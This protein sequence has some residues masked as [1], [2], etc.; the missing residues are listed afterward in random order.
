MNYFFPISVLYNMLKD[1]GNE[2]LYIKTY[3]D[4]VSKLFPFSLYSW[5][6]TTIYIRSYLIKI[7]LAIQ[8]QYCILYSLD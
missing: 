5:F 2:Q 3:F 8:W 1:N 7:L 6:F 4:S